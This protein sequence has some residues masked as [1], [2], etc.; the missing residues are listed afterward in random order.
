MEK[1]FWI[2]SVD[3]EWE[4]VDEAVHNAFGNRDRAIVQYPNGDVQVR[5]QG[6]IS[7]GDYEFLVGG[8]HI[9]TLP[10]AESKKTSK[11]NPASKKKSPAKKKSTVKKKASVKK[12]SKAKKK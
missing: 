8:G 2:K 11:K 7:A 9:E 12:K 1:A 10:A 5:V 3:G 4:K 6:F